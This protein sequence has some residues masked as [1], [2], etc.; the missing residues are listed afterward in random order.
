LKGF[1]V[2][3]GHHLTERSTKGPVS[4]TGP[5]ERYRVLGEMRFKSEG[6]QYRPLGFFGPTRLEYTILVGASKKGANY[7]PR[8]A[9]EMALRRRAEVVADP[10]RSKVLDF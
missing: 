6:V 4:N 2:P 1:S 9:I 3:C 7:D 5:F 10:K 8:D